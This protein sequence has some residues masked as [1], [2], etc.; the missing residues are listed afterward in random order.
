MAKKKSEVG[1]ARMGYEFFRVQMPELALDAAE[2][3]AAPVTIDFGLDVELREVVDI[4]YIKSNLYADQDSFSYAAEFSFNAAL[5]VHELPNVNTSPL[6][7][8][9]LENSRSLVY[10]HLWGLGSNDLGTPAS[11]TIIKI[12][13]KQQN[14]FYPVG[15]Y[16]T[17]TNWTITFATH[18]SG[19]VGGVD[20]TAF[21]ELMVRR[22]KA[23]QAEFEALYNQLRR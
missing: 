1:K 13:D 3:I 2:L 8:V 23:S 10:R 15:G 5:G 14:D 16:T 9:N 18:A 20:I 19:G 7:E 11:N 17:G 6:E 12:V 22:R 21:V 4:M